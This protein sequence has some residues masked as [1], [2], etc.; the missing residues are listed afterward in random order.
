MPVSFKVKAPPGKYGEFIWATFSD[1]TNTISEVG[2][3]NDDTAG[4]MIIRRK[5]PK[6]VTMTGST[7]I[8]KVEI[9]YVVEDL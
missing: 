8:Y 1:T 4:T 5:M 2:L 3:F 9:E 6:T 7:H